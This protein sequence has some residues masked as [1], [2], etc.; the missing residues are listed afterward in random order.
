MALFRHRIMKRYWGIAAP[1]V[2]IKP[3]TAFGHYICSG[4]YTSSIAIGANL[5]Y[6][7]AVRFCFANTFNL[8]FYCLVLLYH[9][10]CSHFFRYSKY[11][12]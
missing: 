6:D 11:C 4:N 10:N 8:Q 1:P 2:L 9:N 7:M 12:E 5:I 3:T